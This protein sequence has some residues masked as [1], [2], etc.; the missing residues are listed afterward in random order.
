MQEH[1]DKTWKRNLRAKNSTFWSQE[2]K[3]DSLETA[4]ATPPLTET[5]S[6]RSLP[7]P[8]S[9]PPSPSLTCFHLVPSPLPLF[10][11]KSMTNI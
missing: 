2:K 8:P 5:E 9:L 1:D 10:P 4:E 6:A 7:L 3:F 11:S